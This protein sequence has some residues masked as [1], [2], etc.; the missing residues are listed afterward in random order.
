MN[1]AMKKS[2]WNSISPYIYSQIAFCA[3]A[4]GFWAYG[5]SFHEIGLMNSEYDVFL[6]IV[7][8]ISASYIVGIAFVFLDKNRTA[9]NKLFNAIMMLVTSS[10]LNILLYILVMSLLGKPITYV[11]IRLFDLS[12]P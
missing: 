7:T 3:F 9:R 5:R 11:L 10:A 2:I 12:P 1:H 6:G 8:G 4:F